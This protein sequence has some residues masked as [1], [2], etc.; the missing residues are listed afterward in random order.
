MV[1]LPRP[2]EKSANEKHLNGH[3]R[4][5]FDFLNNGGPTFFGLACH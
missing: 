2:Q 5:A 1:R 3:V 4:Q